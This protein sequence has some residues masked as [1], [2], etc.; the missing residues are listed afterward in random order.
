MTDIAELGLKVTSDSVVVAKDRLRDLLTQAEATSKGIGGLKLLVAGTLT[1]MASALTFYGVGIKGAIARLNEWDVLQRQVDQAL[2]NT[3]NTA[4][5]S[6]QEIRA[7]AE[8][9]EYRTGRAAEEV[10]Q[11]ATNLA[12]YGFGRKEFY[13]ALGLA[14]DMAAAWGGDL[15]QNVEGLGRALDD[16]INGFA[17]LSKRGVK[18]TQDQKDMAQAF[19]DSNNKVAAQGV[20]FK[21]L[22]DQVKGVAEAGFTGLRAAIGRA[23]E[24]WENAFEDLVSGTGQTRDLRDT[25]ADLAKTVSSPQ[26]IQAVVGFGG[27][28]VKAINAA[29]QAVIALWGAVKDFL[30]W[31]DSKNPANMNTA[32]LKNEIAETQ[33]LMD[34]AKS[35]QGGVG[36]GFMSMFGQDKETRI[37]GYSDKIQELNDRLT[38]LSDPT[39]TDAISKTFDVLRNDKTYDSPAAMFR[40]LSPGTMY[41]Q[42]DNNP[43]AGLDTRTEE[44]KKAAEKA[45]KELANTYA[46][47]MDDVKPLLQAA[48]DPMIELQG[49]LDKLGAL[50]N[51]G[52]ISWEQYAHG[53][54]QANLLA[55]SS[56]LGSVGQ[57]TGI[58]S[59]AFQDNKLLASANAAVNT[60][61][62]ITKA[63]AQGGMFAWPTAIAIGI[64]GAAQIANIL[65]AQPG[66]S[67]V[68]GV[69]AAPTTAAAVQQAGASAAINLT[70][71]GDGAVTVDSFMKQITEQIDAGHH[72]DFVNVVRA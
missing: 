8:Q 22:E 72:Q 36:E 71:T 35:S 13:E 55:A 45:A 65:S 31:L 56:V 23:Q 30:A 43:Y 26:F 33:K 21:A 60:A 40:A 39:K 59:G 68:A 3:G 34:L 10:V 61:E 48:N 57:I 15:K 4:R 46:K 25:L 1:A 5:T 20:V 24:A 64:A 29:A 37:K 14:N 38:Q 47:M 63:L 12:T 9:L 28:M 50:L 41:G 69:G 42:D 11:A 44:T 54:Q 51:K 32:Q 27:L 67:S 18:L 58:L 66:S 19:L 2:K 16:P 70:I 52:Q 62:G 49:N 53:V 7:W 6:S 17:M